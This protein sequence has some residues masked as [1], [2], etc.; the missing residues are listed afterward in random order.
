[1][2]DEVSTEVKRVLIEQDRSLWMNTR[3]QAEMRL[4]VQR[5][6]TDHGM[7]SPD[8][9]KALEL[10]LTEC[11]AALQVLDEELSKVE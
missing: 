5:R 6:L 4:R 11:E 10:S 9:I 2:S 8:Q 7:G 3:F 1:M